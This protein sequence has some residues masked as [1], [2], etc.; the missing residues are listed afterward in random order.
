MPHEIPSSDLPPLDRL[1]RIMRVLRAPGGCPW[2]AEQTH[3]SLV[4]HLLEEAYEVAA[5][6]RGGDRDELVDELGD[7]LLQPFFHAEIAS[8]TGRFNIDDVA[9]AIC[10]KL[11][12]RHPHVFGEA[13]AETAEAVL[14][15]WEA[16]KAGEKS[17]AG[18]AS[19]PAE[20]GP[21]GAYLLKKGNEG[22]PALLAAS[23]LQRKAASVG[24]DWPS[25]APVLEKVREEVEE[26]AAAIDEGR[27]EEIAGEIG[28][29][30]F[31]VVNLARKAGH[32]AEALLDAA[33]R[34]FVRRLCAVEDE[35]LRRGE[36]LDGVS[37]ARMDEAWDRVKAAER[38]E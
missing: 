14:T 18:T 33:N 9:A 36:R 17:T 1:R 19:D 4:R 26:V 22:Q 15:Q 7:L 8:E 34:K 35:L 37:L 20:A 2:D 27:D 25:L 21:R 24:F 13:T 23:K 38:G 10:E 29:L 11:V 30:L 3:E 5:A 28:D 31:A 6:I 32:E 12:R 16:I